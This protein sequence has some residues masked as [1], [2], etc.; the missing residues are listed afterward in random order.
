MKA[1]CKF[2]GKVGKVEYKST[3]NTYIFLGLQIELKKK[4]EY[5]VKIGRHSKDFRQQY[6]T[7]EL[8]SFLKCMYSNLSIST[9]QVSQKKPN[10]RGGKSL[11]EFDTIQP[12]LEYQSKISYSYMSPFT[13]FPVC[14]KQRILN[15][16]RV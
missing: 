14:S 8:N 13:K 3:E 2:I 4:T 9:S 16:S 6:S 1:W 10:K 15:Q 7:L 11:K 12:F 5:I